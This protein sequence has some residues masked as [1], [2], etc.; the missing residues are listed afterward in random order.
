MNKK[1]FTLAE[2]LGVIIIFGALILVVATPIVGQINKQKVKLDNAS[3]KLIYSTTETFLDKNKNS[4]PL[5]NN[6]VYYITLKQL[7]DSK[8]IDEEFIKTYSSDVLSKNSIIKVTVDEDTYTYSLL[9]SNTYNSIGTIY[10][11]ISNGL[12][13]FT[14]M[15]GEYFQDYVDKPIYY[16]GILWDI[17]GK[18]A[19][20]TIK[21]LSRDSITP[22]YVNKGN[23]NYSDS[24]ARKW[25]NTE[26][27]GS[28]VDSSII[29]NQNWCVDTASD[30]S[31]SSEICTNSIKDKVGLLTLSEVNRLASDYVHNSTL[32]VLMTQNNDNTG[33]YF[34]VNTLGGIDLFGHG[35]DLP[36][37]I[38][39]SI[40]IIAEA[41]I[42]SG[43]GTSS[44]PYVLAR[45]NSVSLA[46]V[47]LKDAPITVGMYVKYLNR[48]YRIMKMGD[49]SFKMIL[50]K[51]YSID[52]EVNDSEWAAFS[53]D[54]KPYN[55]N[56]GIGF[57]LNNSKYTSFV[58]NDA[59]NNLISDD[60]IFNGI[61]A[62]KGS[63]YK[64]HSLKDN[65]VVIDASIGLP[66]LGEL[67]ASPNVTGRMTPYWT[68]NEFDEA[69]AYS[70]TNDIIDIR[71]KSDQIYIRPVINI[72]SNAFITSGNGL[73]NNPLVLGGK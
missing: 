11:T 33:S 71:P 29:S 12:N 61:Y 57:Y 49:K 2:L 3:L 60:L 21:L 47:R 64:L 14:Y 55:V 38:R 27:L 1:G 22:I 65:Q 9:P 68:Q 70:I 40:N 34:R 43:T 23:E 42:I 25:L 58:P 32:Y 45:D 44:D 67:F 17:I 63:N 35:Y 72:T 30:N 36:I 48:T 19:D 20:G 37:H 53:T 46:D 52:P 31:L 39:P 16:N 66:K 18:N 6:A 8:F 7:F 26:F 24:Y 28:L 15:D 62:T 56:D 5:K 13:K 41:P 50:S 4:Y 59:N 54:N 51:V 73:Q 69:N 10:D